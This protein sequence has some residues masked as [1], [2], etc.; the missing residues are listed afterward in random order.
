ME[1]P[2]PERR[3]PTIELF[4]RSF[5]R[6]QGAI[7]AVLVTLAAV[8]IGRQVLRQQVWP[9]SLTFSVAEPA[10]DA[11]DWMQSTFSGVTNAISDWLIKYALDPLSDLLARRAVVDHRRWHRAPRM[12]ALSPLQPGRV[13][14]WLCSLAIGVLGTWDLAMDTLSQVLVAVVLSIAIAHPAR[15]RVGAERPVPAGAQTRARR[16]ADDA[17]VRLPGARDLPVPARA[18]SPA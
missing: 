6:R 12:A 13:L 4:G 5:T 1:H 2:R 10:N 15:R 17:G 8:V 11:L 9:E 18:A 7:G 3:K 16:D 14:W